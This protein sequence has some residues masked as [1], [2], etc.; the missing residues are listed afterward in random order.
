[1]K[2]RKNKLDEMQ[3]QRLLHIESAGCWIAFIGLMLVIAAQ[4][5]YYGEDCGEQMLYCNCMCK[6]RCLGQE[7]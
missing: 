2:K 6:E 3:E 4:L 7:V 1:M 5:V